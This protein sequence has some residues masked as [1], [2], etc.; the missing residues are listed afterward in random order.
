[1]AKGELFVLGREDDVIVVG[2]AKFLPEEIE[3]VASEVGG[4]K[5][6]AAAAIGKRSLGSSTQRVTLALHV[7]CPDS[8]DRDCLALAIRQAL[9]SRG[10]PIDHIEFMTGTA[11][12]RTTNGKL[13][14]EAYRE[15][16]AARNE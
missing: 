7:T 1:M 12:L 11:P 3:Q 8:E 6:R 15:L 10:L 9:V 4:S 16:F 2:G 5:V 14:R 13:S